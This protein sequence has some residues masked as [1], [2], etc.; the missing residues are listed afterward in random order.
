MSA[1]PEALGVKVTEQLALPRVPEAFSVQPDEEKVPG[2][3]LWK[4]TVPVGVIGEP[5]GPVSITITVHTADELWATGFG[6]QLTELDTG[7]WLT[8]TLVV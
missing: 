3:L 2:A 5:A 6:E 7:R 1:F 8:F 4:V